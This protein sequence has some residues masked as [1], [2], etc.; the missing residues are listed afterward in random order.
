[1]YKSFYNDINFQRKDELTE[2]SIL[3]HFRHAYES[4]IWPNFWAFEGKRFGLNP[5]KL[6]KFKELSTSTSIISHFHH[7][8]CSSHCPH[9]MF[10]KAVDFFHTNLFNPTQ[11]L[12]TMKLLFYATS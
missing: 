7:V 1:M 3:Q 5:Y 9:D 8:V 10:I 2:Q 4:N 12:P 11:A 6:R